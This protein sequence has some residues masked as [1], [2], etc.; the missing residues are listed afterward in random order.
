MKILNLFAGIGGN[1]TLWGND[2][3]IYAIEYDKD[4]ANIYQ[5]RYPNDIII[6]D[7]AY[8][9]FVKNFHKFEIL[10]ASPP[11]TSHTNLV[12]GIV[13]NRYNGRNFNVKLPDLRLYSLIFFC[14]HHFRGNWV[15]ENVKGYYKPLIKP[16]TIIGRHWI[17]SNIV[18]PPCKQE[19]SE[20]VSR[21]NYNETINDALKTKEINQNI[22]GELLK[23]DL[24]KRK[25]I[26]NNCVVPKEGY[27]ILKC[28]IN[29]K[30]KTLFEYVKN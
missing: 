15:I 25:Q 9:Y 26:I 22:Y 12:H 4:I 30:Q 6:V 7:D 27:Y 14:K 8:D 1:R 28:L 2:H 13:G 17:W 24:M 21:E 20:H 23:L 3:E 29:K 16:S 5:K 19:K 11:C 18:I 10:W